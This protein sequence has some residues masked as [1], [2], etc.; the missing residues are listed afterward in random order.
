MISLFVRDE[1]K[2][3]NI[4]SSLLSPHELQTL[5]EK[6]I[7]EYDQQEIDFSIYKKVF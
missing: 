1:L 6:I 5:Y 4:N 7:K 2:R 3:R